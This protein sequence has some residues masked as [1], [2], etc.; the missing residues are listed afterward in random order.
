MSALNGYTVKW[1]IKDPV[2]DTYG[3]RSES[4]NSDYSLTLTNLNDSKDSCKYNYFC[5]KYYIIS[6]I[7]IYTCQ[8]QSQII[9]NG[10]Y[11]ID[12]QKTRLY[13]REY[14]EYK[15]MNG[16]MDRWID[17]L[18][19]D[20]IKTEIDGWMSGLI[21]DLIKTRINGWMGGLIEDLIKTRIDGWMSGLIEDLIKTGTFIY[22]S[23][24]NFT[25]FCSN[26][27]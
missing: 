17:G 8:V 15:W 1:K 9:Y 13:V 12:G 19:E 5:T 27:N 2:K 10:P 21:E 24:I 22:S 6:F 20:L 23:S 7:V 4:H 14:S 3:E 16:W 25:S 18:I 26:W 11:K